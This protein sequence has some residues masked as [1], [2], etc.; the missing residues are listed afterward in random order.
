MCGCDSQL[1]GSVEVVLLLMRTVNNLAVTNDHEAAVTEIAR[2]Q[3]VDL[4]VEKHQ[5]RRTTACSRIL[6][7]QLKSEIAS[8]R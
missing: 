3:S 7:H 8:A 1:V 6:K 5:A 2:V 4:L